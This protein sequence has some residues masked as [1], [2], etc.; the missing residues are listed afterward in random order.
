M[1]MVPSESGPGPGLPARRLEARHGPGPGPPEGAW[2]ITPQDGREVRSKCLAYQN[3]HGQPRQSRLRNHAE[4][5]VRLSE[6]HEIG[7]A[8]G[9]GFRAAGSA[10]PSDSDF[11]PR[12]P[13]EKTRFPMDGECTQLLSLQIQ[14]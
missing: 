10:Q 6:G 3:S 8:K 13:L 12:Q 5:Q 2:L 14:I 4:S 9:L 1:M 7:L 11:F